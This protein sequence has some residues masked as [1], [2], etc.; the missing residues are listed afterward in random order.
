MWTRVP[1]H[2]SETNMST[3]HVWRGTI[4]FL[5]I[6]HHDCQHPSFN[7][8]KFS[9]DCCKMSLFYYWCYYLG[10]HISPSCLLLD[11]CFS[12]SSALWQQNKLRMVAKMQIP[13]TWPRWLNS[14]SLRASQKNLH[15]NKLPSDS[16]VHSSLRATLL[17]M[18]IPQICWA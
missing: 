13:G 6:C 15:F 12:K 18:F 10:I 11:Q 9:L 7:P 17:E 5:T 2:L 14:A 3:V 8:N 16:N 4:P 1:G